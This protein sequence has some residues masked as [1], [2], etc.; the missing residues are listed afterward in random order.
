MIVQITLIDCYFFLDKKKGKLPKYHPKISNL[1]KDAIRPQP[2]K[3]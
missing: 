1:S 2:K 3:S